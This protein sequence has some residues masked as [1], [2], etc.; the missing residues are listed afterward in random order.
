MTVIAS[1]CSRIFTVRLFTDRLLLLF[2]RNTCEGRWV[3]RPSRVDASSAWYPRSSVLP[4]GIARG[5]GTGATPQIADA[6]GGR[7]GVGTRTALPWVAAE[8]SVIHL[9]VKVSLLG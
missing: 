7:G 5:P 8:P 3:S 6:H 4:Y 9:P 2:P 1:F